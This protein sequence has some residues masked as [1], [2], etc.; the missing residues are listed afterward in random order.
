[1]PIYEWECPDCGHVIELIM[2]FKEME[3]WE[4]TPVVCDECSKALYKRKISTG[5]DFKLNGRGWS[6]DGYGNQGP[7]DP[8][9]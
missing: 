1:M 9:F 7:N 2:S 3:A 4:E 6:Q 5:T 8:S